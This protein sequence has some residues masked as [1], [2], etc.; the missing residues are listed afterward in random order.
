MPQLIF[1]DSFL[2]GK[3]FNL[4]Q[5]QLMSNVENWSIDP[6]LTL[7]F[8]SFVIIPQMPHHFPPS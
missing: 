4:P 3:I 5:C 6:S 1:L 8:I 7:T 2:A